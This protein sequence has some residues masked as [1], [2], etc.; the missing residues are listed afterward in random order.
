MEMFCNWIVVMVAQLYKSPVLFEKERM[1]L[2]PMARVCNPGYPG[3][4]NQEDRSSRPVGEDSLEDSMLKIPNTVKGCKVVE[5]LSSKREALSSSPS[6][7]RKE[8]KERERFRR[9]LE[10]GPIRILSWYS[11]KRRGSEDLHNLRFQNCKMGIIML[12]L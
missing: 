1:G 4:R 8:R 7:G 11:R 12:A 3:G 10:W 2:V 9:I 5:R 6:T